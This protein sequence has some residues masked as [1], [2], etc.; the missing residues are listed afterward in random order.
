M[1][2]GSG[3]KACTVMRIGEQVVYV[4]H[5]E[6]EQPSEQAHMMAAPANLSGQGMLDNSIIAERDALRAD[7]ANKTASFE[8]AMKQIAEAHDLAGRA[9]A[10]RDSLRAEVERLTATNNRYAGWIKEGVERAEMAARRFALRWPF[11][12][13]HIMD[14]MSDEIERLRKGREDG[15]IA[16]AD[17]AI[18][19]RNTLG[20]QLGNGGTVSLDPRLGTPQPEGEPVGPR[21]MRRW[22]PIL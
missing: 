15:K 17:C 3:D 7:L 18:R 6:P 21:P 13:K 9:I 20:L 12:G 14:V 5:S 19:D 11:G 4:H 16:D 8:C 10:A 22:V 2:F 1:D